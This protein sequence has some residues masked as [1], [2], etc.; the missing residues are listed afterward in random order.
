MTAAGEV[1]KACRIE[2]ESPEWSVVK[3]DEQPVGVCTQVERSRKGNTRVCYGSM[4]I[5]C[6]KKLHHSIFAI[7]LSKRLTVK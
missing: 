2:P 6:G 5:L 3:Y 4:R 1:I 7:T